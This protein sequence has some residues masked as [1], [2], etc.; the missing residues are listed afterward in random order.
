MEQ[1]AAAVA[2]QGAGNF[3]FGNATELPVDLKTEISTSPGGLPVPPP[4]ELFTV[5]EDE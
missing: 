2:Y 4:P 3:V 1:S 5:P